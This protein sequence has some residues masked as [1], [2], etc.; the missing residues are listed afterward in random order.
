MFAK[1]V[2]CL[3]YLYP[4]TSWIALNIVMGTSNGRAARPDE[5]RVPEHLQELT[6]EFL[7]YPASFYWMETYQSVEGDFSLQNAVLGM[8][9]ESVID[10]EG[11][12]FRYDFY[13]FDGERFL[14]FQDYLVTTEELGSGELWIEEL[15]KLEQEVQQ[16]SQSPSDC[17]DKAREFAA[18]WLQSEE[19]NLRTLRRALNQHKKLSLRYYPQSSFSPILAMPGEHFKAIQFYQQLESVNAMLLLEKKDFSAA[20]QSLANIYQWSE[21]LQ[22]Q[23][24]TLNLIRAMKGV[25]LADQVTQR[26]L[27][28][29]ECPKQLKH[30]II[31]QLPQVRIVS[32][33]LHIAVDSLERLLVLDGAASIVSD[34][35]LGGSSVY[36]F[37]DRH[38]IPYGLLDANYLYSKL[39]EDFDRMVKLVD[40]NSLSHSVEVA[41]NWEKTLSIY[42]HRFRPRWQTIAARI[43]FL[44]TREQFSQRVYERLSC[45]LLPGIEALVNAQ[46]QLRKA[47]QSPPYIKPENTN[48]ASGD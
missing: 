3:M 28:S 44:E 21:R 20:W 2:L 33:N 40:P 14:T 1:I 37:Q 12:P 10:T 27:D 43:L 35:F 25:S 8:A 16:W 29:P 6:P 19:E 46:I 11:L 26:L 13:E 18:G 32:P 22:Q 7:T 34:R 39:N 42:Q 24:H 48:D 47:Q 30:D 31:N 36:D 15:L 38:Q 5:Y 45:Q 23:P 9:P 4:G 41:K 17:S